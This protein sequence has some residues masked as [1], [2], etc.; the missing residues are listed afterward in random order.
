MIGLWQTSEK[1]RKCVCT[2]SKIA[3]LEYDYLRPFHVVRIP[4]VRIP[5]SRNSRTCHP[6]KMIGFRFLICEMGV[7]FTWGANQSGM[8]QTLQKV[9]LEICVLNGFRLI[10]VIGL[11]RLVNATLG[12]W[13]YQC[14]WKVIPFWRAFALQNSGRNCSPP[15]D[16]AFLK[17]R[18]LRVFLSGG[19]FF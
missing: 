5:R 1:M 10:L 2:I 15:P 18:L 12:T 17:L 11:P 19:V 8:Y 6:S 16:L 13:P 14:M 7:T 9:I 3:D 4:L